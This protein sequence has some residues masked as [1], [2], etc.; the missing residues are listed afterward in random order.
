MKK[1]DLII[2]LL[3]LI[4]SEE[5]RLKS[6]HQLVDSLL[7]FLKMIGISSEQF[8]FMLNNPKVESEF[9]S[10]KIDIYNSIFSEEEL[11]G[12]IDFF[13]SP[14]G[15]L[16]KQKQHELVN[17]LSKLE[18]EKIIFIQNL[19]KNDQIDKSCN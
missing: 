7:P 4:D 5:D 9:F 18:K 15:K 14:I 3:S 19:Y 1:K 8:I 11:S 16:Y 12:L 13:S 2:K 6:I 10:K 17:E